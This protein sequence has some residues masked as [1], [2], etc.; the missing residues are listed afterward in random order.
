MS[1][2]RAVAKLVFVVITITA[3]LPAASSH[4]DNV[5]YASSTGS[6]TSCTAA[7]PCDIVG[8]I[9]NASTTVPGPDR[10]ICLSAVAGPSNT[11]NFFNAN[12]Q[13]LEIDCPLGFLATLN[14]SGTN[15]TTR[16]RGLTFTN[17]IFN[18]AIRHF[19][20]G[21]LILEDCAFVDDDERRA[22]HRA[23]WSVKPYDQK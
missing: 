23:E 1:L 20:S 21:T 15:G 11:E 6:G 13:T 16:V 3:F 14:I 8:A 19:G 7:Q 2:I 22:R 10:V 18:D 5:V 17:S 4:A 12:N 9:A